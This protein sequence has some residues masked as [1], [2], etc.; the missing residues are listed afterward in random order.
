MTVG[1]RGEQQTP[2]ETGGARGGIVF[3]VILI[4]RVTY[5]ISKELVDM[6]GETIEQTTE[7]NL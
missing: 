3:I 7:S 4:Y 6:G 5:P 2:V 1:R